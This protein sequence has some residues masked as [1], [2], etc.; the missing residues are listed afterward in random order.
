MSSGPSY[1]T[2]LVLKG[3][4]HDEVEVTHSRSFKPTDGRIDS[5]SFRFYNPTDFKSGAL[6]QRISARGVSY[7]PEPESVRSERDS[8]G[9]SL[10][11]VEWKGL[12]NTATVTETYT[13]SLSLGLNR[14]APFPFPLNPRD[15]PPPAARFLMPLRSSRPTTRR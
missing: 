10:T 7:T 14:R 8:F 4:I 6:S 5:L 15:I 12:N 1:G 3:D 9:N 2:T 13:V 11:V